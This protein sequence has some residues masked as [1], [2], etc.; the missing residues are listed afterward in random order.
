MA[1]HYTGTITGNGAVY[2]DGDS[3]LVAIN[4]GSSSVWMDLTERPNGRIRG[5]YGYD[6]GGTVSVTGGSTYANPASFSFSGI[7]GDGSIRGH[8]STLTLEG[9]A[10]FFTGGTATIHGGTITYTANWAFN[11]G[12]LDGSGTAFGTLTGPKLKQEHE[13]AVKL[14]HAIASMGGADSTSLTTSSPVSNTTDL[15]TTLAPHH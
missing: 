4:S 5:T 3:G 13:G 6:V 15:A 2:G 7:T 8:G 11:F 9:G 10:P 1:E 12:G 14:S